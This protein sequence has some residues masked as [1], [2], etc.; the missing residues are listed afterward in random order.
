MNGDDLYDYAQSVGSRDEFVKFVELLNENLKSHSDEWE[1]S[2]LP[3]F[4]DGLSVFTS[5]MEGYYKNVGETVDVEVISWRMMAQML[6]AAK[7]CS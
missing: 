2:D 3:S 5:D 4:F 6:L 1:N 7:V